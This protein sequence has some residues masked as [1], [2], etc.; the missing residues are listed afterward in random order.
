MDDKEDVLMAVYRMACTR[1]WNEGPKGAICGEEKRGRKQGDQ[2]I[3]RN[4][5]P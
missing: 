4:Q 5:L 3:V 1:K 2:A